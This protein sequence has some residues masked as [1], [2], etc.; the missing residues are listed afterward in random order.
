[1]YKVSTTLDKVIISKSLYEKGIDG[2]IV[3]E[4]GQL[5]VKAMN[6][7]TPDLEAFN[8]MMKQRTDVYNK[9]LADEQKAWDSKN[10]KFEVSAKLSLEREAIH[11]E[12]KAEREKEYVV[13]LSDDRWRALIDVCVNAQ[14]AWYKAIQDRNACTDTEKQDK[15]IAPSLNEFS[16]FG[17]FVQDLE[18][19]D[20]VKG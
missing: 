15:I 2:S 13:E 19:A 4:K 12:A 9:N 18:S 6:T 16:Q 1:M 3:F 7:V 17:E 8:I 20:K 11:A 14:K 5:S 10:G